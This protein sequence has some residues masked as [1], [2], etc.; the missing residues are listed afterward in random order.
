[1][2]CGAVSGFSVAGHSVAIGVTCSRTAVAIARTY[3]WYGIATF[4]VQAG[5]IGARIGVH[6]TTYR[7]R[8][9]SP[10]IGG[11]VLVRI[12]SPG[13]ARITVVAITMV[14]EELAVSR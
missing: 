4:E 10:R 2:S 14:R 11:S 1:M 12:T 7:S 9:T 5:D 3:F 13:C 8:Y 6:W